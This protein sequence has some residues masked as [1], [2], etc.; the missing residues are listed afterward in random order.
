MNVEEP[1]KPATQQGILIFW[2]MKLA[3]N[4]KRLP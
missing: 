2:Y 1:L 4:R 3:G